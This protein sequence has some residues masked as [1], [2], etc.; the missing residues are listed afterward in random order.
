[1]E[2]MD[3]SYALMDL[4]VHG[5]QEPWEDSPAGW[6]QQRTNVRTD[7]GAP[8]WPP[9]A[10]WPGGRPVAQWPRLDVGHSDDLSATRTP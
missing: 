8:E 6:P 1:M 9:V 3:H 2:A 7:A 4:T 5:R 10:Q